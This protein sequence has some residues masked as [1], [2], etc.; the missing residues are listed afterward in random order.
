MIVLNYSL[1]S[2]KL[3]QWDL[4]ILILSFSITDSCLSSK[5]ASLILCLK[6]QVWFVHKGWSKLC[7]PVPGRG[8]MTCKSNTGARDPWS[9]IEGWCLFPTFIRQKS[10]L[11]SKAIPVFMQIQRPGPAGNFQ[12]NPGNSC[13]SKWFWIHMAMKTLMIWISWDFKHISCCSVPQTSSLLPQ[14]PGI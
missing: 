8:T 3:L 4:N 11:K 6:K 2:E 5:S 13:C 10:E 14:G 7:Y 12:A 1:P 9:G